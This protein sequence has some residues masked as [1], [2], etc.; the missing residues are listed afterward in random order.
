MFWKFSMPAPSR[1]RP[2][3]IAYPRDGLMPI[4]FKIGASHDLLLPWVCSEP[5]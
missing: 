2:K 5:R 3:G 1:S 4:P